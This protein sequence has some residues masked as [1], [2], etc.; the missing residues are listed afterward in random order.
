VLII[1]SILK[2][3]TADLELCSQSVDNSLPYIRAVLIYLIHEPSLIQ[4]R[5]SIYQQTTYSVFWITISLQLDLSKDYW[6]EYLKPILGLRVS[7]LIEYLRQY[8]YNIV[9]SFIFLWSPTAEIAIVFSS[10]KV[11]H[12]LV[13]LDHLSVSSLVWN[14]NIKMD[15]LPSVG[16]LYELQAIHDTG[17]LLSQA[18]PEDY[19]H[20][21]NPILS[22][23][24]HML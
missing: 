21:V 2:L 15:I 10:L 11:I 9:I 23:F 8:T 14:N 24:C 12:R 19:W 16:I 6:R 17:Y 13:K 3:E 1:E 4:I 18:S 20:Q 7:R 5:E 22:Y